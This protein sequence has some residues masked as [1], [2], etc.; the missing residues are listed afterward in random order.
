MEKKKDRFR[1]AIF[2]IVGEEACPFYSVGEEIKVEGSGLSMS[3]YKPGCL[4]LARQIASILASKSKESFATSESITA[5]VILFLDYIIFSFQIL[6]LLDI[7]LL[8]LSL[9]PH[10][11]RISLK[12][13]K[14]S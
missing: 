4:Y 1:D 3:A 6:F 13:Y 14:R 5:I 2:V 7:Q 9:M 12:C 8:F 10:E 11:N